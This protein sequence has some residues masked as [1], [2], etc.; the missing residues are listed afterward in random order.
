MKA[1]SL[2]LVV[3]FLFVSLASIADV[4]NDLC[5]VANNGTYTCVE[6]GTC[7]A[8][9]SPVMV[10]GCWP[11]T[12]CTAHL[13]VYTTTTVVVPKVKGSSFGLTGATEVDKSQDIPLEVR[14]NYICGLQSCN[15]FYFTR[16]DSLYMECHGWKASGESCAKP[17]CPDDDDPHGP[18]ATVLM[19]GAN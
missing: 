15:F 10:T 19:L 5:C 18:I 14:V 9:C 7:V 13:G 3:V 2:K 6:P 16:S 8:D 11:G 4:V 1:I 12:I 17:N